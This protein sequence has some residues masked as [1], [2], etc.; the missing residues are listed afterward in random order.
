M[1]KPFIT[2]L[3]LVLSLFSVSLQAATVSLDPD[4]LTVQE[5]NTFT[6]DLE[7][8]FTDAAGDQPGSYAG[9]V[10]INFDDTLIDFVSFEI[11]DPIVQTALNDN[12]GDVVVGFNGLFGDVATIGTYTFSAL[13]DAGGNIVNLILSDPSDGSFF[14]FNPTV[15][16]IFPEFGS[17]SVEVVPLP[18]AVWLFGSALFGM[19]AFI[20][21]R[22]VPA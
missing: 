18:A 6:I 7:V 21:K 16:P 2:G 3:M 13:P 1:Y 5:G 4:S 17:A 19:G 10:N 22:R 20:R 12:G 15:T 9:L 14:N 8:D 11:N